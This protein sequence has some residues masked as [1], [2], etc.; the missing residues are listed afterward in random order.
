[1]S[2]AT[3]PRAK[4]TQTSLLTDLQSIVGTDHA[5]PPDPKS[6]QFVIDGLVPQVIIHPAS[7]EEVAAVMNF[8]NQRGLAVIPQGE[9]RITWIGNLPARYDIALSVSRLNQVIEYEP[10]DLTITCQAGAKFDD[11][12]SP[13]EANGQSLPVSSESCVGRSLALPL[14][15]HT[16]AGDFAR[17]YTIGLRVVTADG[18]IIRPGGNVVKNVAGYDLT[19]LFI[20]SMGT[21]G[22]IVEATFKLTPVPESKEHIRLEFKSSSD[23]CGFA[24]ELRRR[25][26][27]VSR[28]KLSRPMSIGDTHAS[29][30]GALW[31]SVD[32]AGSY[33]RSRPITYRDNQPFGVLRGKPRCNSSSIA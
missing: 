16:H 11:G 17:D 8:A 7:Y 21:I 28:D 1:M 9:G 3:T 32:L 22:V 13:L 23:A 5:L 24:L 2:G 20:G 14:S 33:L 31:L 12:N 29:P 25:G 4:M 27:S 26:L 6:T 18:R 15:G 19:K 30:L 10:A